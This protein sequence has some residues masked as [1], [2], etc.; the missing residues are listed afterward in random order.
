[1]PGDLVLRGSI[2]TTRGRC[3]KQR[4]RCVTGELHERTALS[5]SLE[6]KTTLI[7]L[8]RDAEVAE[9]AAALE[10]YKV[11][12]AELEARV[13]ESLLELRLRLAAVPAL[14]KERA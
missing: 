6:N 9:V 2:V 3:G 11:A 1:M 7:T 4:C 14:A 13:A 5:I 8:R 10:R 12:R